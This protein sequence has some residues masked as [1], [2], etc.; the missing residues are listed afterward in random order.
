MKN[1]HVEFIDSL[2]G[3]AILVVFLFH[4]LGVS[5]GLD[6]LPWNGLSRD[7]NAPVSFLALLPLTFGWA[8]VAIFFVISG[9][10]IHLSYARSVNAGWGVFF[11]RRFF[12]IYPPYI[13]VLLML[14]IYALIVS[15]GD[16]RAVFF[17]ALQFVVHAITL[18]NISAGTLFAISPPFW[19][20]AVEIQLYAIY[21]FL[22][23]FTRKYGWGKALTITLVIEVTIRI[24]QTIVTLRSPVVSFVT[25]PTWIFNSPF[26]YWFSWSLGAYLAQCIIDGKGIKLKGAP[27]YFVLAAAFIS[28][29]FLFSA[30]FSFTLFSL[31]TAVL[32]ARLLEKGSLS[33]RG[34]YPRLFLK[35]ISSLGV[36][37]YSFYLLH[38]PLL[39]WCSSIIIS[40]SPAGIVHPLWL[41]TACTLLLL[42][43]FVFCS[44]FYRFIE[45]PSISFGKKVINKI[46]RDRSEQVATASDSGCL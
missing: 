24:I 23:W 14:S 19:S 4:A 40:M 20:I 22:I 18:H 30:H 13:L 11:A 16:A 38:Q 26:A 8:G 17:I 33:N 44:Y 31:A 36:V 25:E 32:C 28:N 10:C 42:P 2:R 41:F 15:W 43:I 46:F 37:S 9:F 3:V 27:F 6:Q 29:L 35:Y 7:Y 5:Y 45:R 12:R 39:R 1:D 21:P 34:N